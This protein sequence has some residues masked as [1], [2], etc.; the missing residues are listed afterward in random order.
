LLPVLGGERRQTDEFLAERLEQ[1]CGLNRSRRRRCCLFIKRAQ[2]HFGRYRD[3]AD[4]EIT[5]RLASISAKSRRPLTGAWRS[6]QQIRLT[7]HRS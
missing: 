3:V 5:G 2:D 1:V 7:C 6:T 4:V